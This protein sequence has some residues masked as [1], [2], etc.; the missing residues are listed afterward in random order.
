L[1]TKPSFFSR[2]AALTWKQILVR[3]S[4]FFGIGILGLIIGIVGFFYIVQGGFFGAIP[5]DEELKQMKNYEASEVYSSDSVLLGRFFIENRSDVTWKELSPHLYN[6]LVATEDVRFYKHK[7]IDQRSLMRV[8]FKSIIL[9]QNTGGGST[10]TQQ[11]AKNYF[12]RKDYGVFTMP[13][14]KI[15]EAILANRI[16]HLYL[17]EEI[18]LFYL[19]TVSFGENTYGIK[20]ACERYFSTNTYDISLQDAALLIG[21]LKGPSY[22]HPQKYPERALERRNTVLHQLYKYNYLTAEELADAQKTKINLHF[23]RSSSTDGI[24]TY[25]RAFVKKEAEKILVKTPK[26]DGSYYNLYTDGLKIKTTIHSKLQQYAEEAVLEHLTKLQPKL[27]KELASDKFFTKNNSLVLNA[28]KQSTRYKSLKAEGREEKDIISEL[29]KKVTMTIFTLKGEKEISLSPW[30][31]TILSLSQLQA[32]FLVSNPKNGQVLAWVG[33]TSFLYFPYDH[34]LSRRQVGSTFKPIVYAQALEA[35]KNPCDF[36]SNQEITYA[37]YDNWTPQNSDG[38]NKIGNYSLIG[39]LT[40]S[41]N[42]IS[43]KLAMELGLENVIQLAQKL[44]IKDTL[45]PVPSLALG[46]ADISLNTMV[47]V[48]GAFA[49]NGIRADMQSIKEIKNQN[50]K[51]IYKAKTKLET[52]LKVQTAKDITNMLCSVV[53]SGTAQ[54]LRTQYHFQG[55]IA[56]KTGTTQNHSDGWFMGYT[57]RYVAGVWVGADQPII[58]FKSIVDGQGANLALPIWANFYQKVN[59]DR[60]FTLMCKSPFPFENN[61]NCPLYKEENLL[62]KIFQKDKKVSHRN[63]Y[64]PQPK[65]PKEKK[66]KK[67]FLFF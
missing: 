18:L 36:I 54:R 22:Y 33:G 47:N 34:V 39:A 42:T 66:K 37:E 8:L 11:L 41:V 29:K 26:A 12:G 65:A 19:N 46:V 17:K 27:E 32:G 44:G 53:D 6:A 15:K 43:V 3:L 56:G 64:S 49:N 14:A 45:P 25:F 62:Q 51:L 30:D 38:E 52:V 50:G 1:T 21:L 61:L 57:S 35:G 4:I 7:G 55:Q 60:Q 2:I 23:K 59:K 5:N 13:V 10:L 67:R 20:T 24:A 48:Y 63:G 40:K 58:R 16:E 9:R 31:S 28:I